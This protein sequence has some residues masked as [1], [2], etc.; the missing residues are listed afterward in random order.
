MDNREIC[1]RYAKIAN[2]LIENM[3][4]LIGIRDETIIYLKSTAEKKSH[5]KRVL[6][7]CEKVQEKN[8]WAIPCDYTI[9]LFE[10][11]LVQLSAEQEVMVIMHELLH[12]GGGETKK[13]KG[14]DLEDFKLMIDTWGAHYLE[15]GVP[16]RLPE[17]TKGALLAAEE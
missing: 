8:K 10:P 14:H 13:V 16:S 9:T 4:E 7:Q 2:Y 12:V 11:N 17:I 3:P 15:P 5:G 1:E 6:G